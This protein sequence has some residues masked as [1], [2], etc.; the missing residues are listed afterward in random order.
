MGQLPGIK[1]RFIVEYEVLYVFDKIK[2]AST[3]SVSGAFWLAKRGL[4]LCLVFG[5]HYVRSTCSIFW[6]R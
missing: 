4:I 1:S 2:K 3:D 5:H 6:T